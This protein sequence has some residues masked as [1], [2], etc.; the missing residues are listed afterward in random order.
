[1]VATMFIGA[2]VTLV[3]IGLFRGGTA[4]PELTVETFTAAQQRWRRHG[5]AN[6][7]V[8]IRVEGRQPA[9]YRVEVVDGIAV[10]ADRNG[11]PLKQD[12]TFATWSVRGMFGTMD[13]DVRNA[14]QQRAGSAAANVAQL[15]LR[16]LF[17]EELG[18]PVR[19]ERVEMVKFG[20]N[21]SV[22]WEVVAF[23]P[24]A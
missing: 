20:N 11:R 3:V 17:D 9:T 6:Y 16:A 4:T 8:E 15:R 10:R 7:I 23:E 24:G 14:E 2:A 12:R 21:R 19:Y 5:P 1:M 22:T 13:S 18:Y